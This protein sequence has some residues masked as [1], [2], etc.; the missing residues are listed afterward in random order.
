MDEHLFC[1]QLLALI[2]EDVRSHTTPAQRKTSWTWKSGRDAQFWVEDECIWQGHAHC[3]WAARYN[4][5]DR[6]LRDNVPYY[7]TVNEEDHNA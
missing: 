7:D 3:K 4:G 1:R 5:W 6:W 2:M